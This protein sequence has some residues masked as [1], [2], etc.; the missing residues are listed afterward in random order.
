[1]S[2][3]PLRFARFLAGASI[4]LLLHFT[5][6]ADCAQDPATASDDLPSSTLIYVSDYFS[7]VGQDARGHVAF[8]LDTNRGRD[9]DAYQAEHFLVFHDEQKGWIDL[10][11][12]GRF[13]Y[14]NKELDRIPDSPFFQFRGSPRT[15]L[16]VTSEK[17]RL[18]LRVEPLIPR[19]KNSHAGAIVWMSSASAKL[20]WQGRT[21]HGRVIYEYLVMPDFNR[22]TRT[23]W[24]M[25]KEFQGL[26]LAA[27]DYADVYAH[28]QLSEHIA[29]LIGTVSGFAA[30]DEE[31]QSMKDLNVTTL[32]REWTLGFYRWPAAWRITWTGPNG[33]AVLRL[34]QSDRKK[35]GNWAIGGFAMSIVRGE[36]DYAGKQ[37]PVYGLA[38]LI[39]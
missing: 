1:M 34:M 24:G 3:N 5:A 18:T 29:P 22:L 16:T 36:L 38:E 35:I 14:T 33:P 20:T 7:F 8:A 12:N 4:I 2:P 15:G 27:G 21:V 30:F 9:G 32:H 28:S 19:R 11:G 10:A 39:M 17:N 6:H 26:Y 25:W 31:T 13:E 37:V 23:Y